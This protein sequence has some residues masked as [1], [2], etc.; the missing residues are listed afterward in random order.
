MSC[1]SINNHLNLSNLIRSFLSFNS[2]SQ[3]H[4]AVIYFNISLHAPFSALNRTLFSLFICGSLMDTENGLVFSLPN[5]NPWEFIVEVPHSIKSELSFKANFDQLLPLLS[6]I[7]PKDNLQEVTG[8]NYRLHVGDEEELV[9]RFLKA[10]EDRTI[11]RLATVDSNNVEHLVEFPPLTNHDECRRFI[12]N[13]LVNHA[14]D[15]P[16]NKI[17]ELSFTK[18]L[19]RRARF[20]IGHYFQ[21]NQSIQQL[22]S[23]VLT[24]MIEEARA[25][26]NI[27]FRDRP[28]AYR[29]FLVYDPWFA[30]HILHNDWN[31]VRPNLQKLFGNKDPRLS[32]E[33]KNKDYLIECLAWLIDIPY[34]MFQQILHDR[35]FILTENFAYKLFHVHERK[36]TRLPLIIEGDTGVGKTFLLKFYAALLHAKNTRDHPENTI[37]PRIAHHMN[38]WLLETIIPLI[39][40]QEILVKTFV[41]QTKRKILGLDEND[42]NNLEA[43]PQQLDIEYLNKIKSALK[44]SEYNE[45]ILHFMWKSL[46]TIA[47]D[48]RLEIKD[49]LIEEFYIYVSK[50]LTDYRLIES[51][52]NL[53]K[54]LEVI[55]SPT[56]Q[57]SIDL[58]QEYLF[59]SQIKPIF[60]RLLLHPGITEEQI[61]NFMNPIIELARELSVIELVVFFDEVNTST[62]LG[63]FKEMFMDGTI[64][65]RDI[66]RNIFFTAAINPYMETRDEDRIHRTDFNVYQLP[67]SLE[68]LVV[69]YGALT[70]DILGEYISKKISM[71]QVNS[72]RSNGTAMPL[73]RFVQETLANCILA[74]QRFCEE[75]LGANT[76]SQRE[77]QRCFT[78]I[79]FFWRMRYDDELENGQ[80]TSDPNP[81]RCI[82]LS[83]ALIYYFRL[84]TEEH[85]KQKQLRDIPSRE[86]LAKVL[87]AYITDF[88]V[89]IENDLRD[90]VNTNNFVIPTGVAINQAV[91]SKS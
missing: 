29:V 45:K 16:R 51:S 1:F 13:C 53:Q 84:P 80:I 89:V 25:L 52:D 75:R 43:P 50:Q 66:P 8:F 11:D 63:L 19:Y 35:K 62:C 79:E 67:Q 77:I 30:L 83:L 91:R 41:H 88:E 5:D 12:D 76:V 28:N 65:G 42:E 81:I 85:I 32:D 18:F 36:L 23:T 14:P 60:Y 64:H 22:G 9:A 90:F 7:T 39:E 71:F 87:S 69:P 55:E 3:N 37:V 21:M 4:T 15:V 6:I 40:N 78:L 54:L 20:F 82:A 27:N 61:V 59:Q 10:F 24:Q 2:N 73:D 47:N 68:N 49:K 72:S 17:C 57:L 38:I 70:S 31:Y 44:Q 74:A 58:C 86:E 34:E 46:L 48:N 56:I 33:Y 26:T